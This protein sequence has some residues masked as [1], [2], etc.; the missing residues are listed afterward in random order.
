MA[1]KCFVYICLVIVCVFLSA[2]ASSESVS[3]ELKDS[4]I[5]KNV[6][7]AESKNHRHNQL[8]STASDLECAANG[9]H[10]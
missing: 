8:Q 9:N 5:D 4:V 3:G 6:K 2:L 10:Y 7:I 1:S